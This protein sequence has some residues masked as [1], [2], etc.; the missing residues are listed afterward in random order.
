MLIPIVVA[1]IENTVVKMLP[2]ENPAPHHDRLLHTTFYLFKILLNF[3]LALSLLRFISLS[4]LLLSLTSFSLKS[5][6]SLSTNSRSLEI[7]SGSGSSMKIGFNSDSR[8]ISYPK[9]LSDFYF[10]FNSYSFG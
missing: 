6:A 7:I 8:I 2:L 4:L 1:I 3:P 5:V 10:Y 9:F